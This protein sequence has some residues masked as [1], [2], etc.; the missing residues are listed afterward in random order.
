MD[1]KTATDI[2][3]YNLKSIQSIITRLSNISFTLMS[4]ILGLNTILVPLIFSLNLN[5]TISYVI[6][7][8]QIL[9][10]LIFCVAHCIN[11]KNERIF[12]K[13]YNK[14][15][16]INLD[17]IIMNEN[18]SKLIL[19]INSFFI[20]E[21]KNYKITNFKNWWLIIKSWTSIIWLC[22]IFIPII[23]LMIILFI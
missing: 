9:I 19:E 16:E 15:I 12:R 18:P 3:L 5:K 6:S 8:I 22:I 7:S 1:K 10:S 2:H 21:K 13:I 17:E 23:E 4:I 20:E 14:K 11:L